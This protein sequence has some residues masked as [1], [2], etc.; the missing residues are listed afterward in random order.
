MRCVPLSLHLQLHFVNFA[1]ARRTRVRSCYLFNLLNKSLTLCALL[2][3][4][5]MVDKENASVQLDDVQRWITDTLTWAYMGT[6]QIWVVFLVVLYVSRLGGVKLGK[7]NDEPGARTA[8]Q[9][10]MLQCCNFYN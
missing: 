8:V 10:V 5:C 6:Q 1:G 4:W 3:I 9:S 7:P 2:Q